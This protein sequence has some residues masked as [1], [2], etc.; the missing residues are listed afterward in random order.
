MVRKI[1]IPWVNNLKNN[2]MEINALT[3]T[4]FFV[5]TFI[6]HLVKLTIF[7]R[8]GSGGTSD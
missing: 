8:M 5:T 7:A 4:A 2:V 1:V 6:M 3:S